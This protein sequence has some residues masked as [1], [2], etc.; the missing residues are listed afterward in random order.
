MPKQLCPEL[1]SVLR[2]GARGSGQGRE[3]RFGL[4]ESFYLRPS[5]YPKTHPVFNTEW[6]W[7]FVSFGVGQS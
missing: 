5:F 4:K 2:H 7:A 1:E 3:Y 6:K